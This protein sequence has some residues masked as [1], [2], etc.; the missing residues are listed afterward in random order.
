MHVNMANEEISQLL[1]NLTAGEITSASGGESQEI[2]NALQSVNMQLN[3]IVTL[4]N[5]GNMTE[6]MTRLDS[7]EQELDGF[8]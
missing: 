8:V 3:E 6:V 7:A 2:S 4:A 5:Y 1:D